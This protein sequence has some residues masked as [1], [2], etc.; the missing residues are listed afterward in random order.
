VGDA[1]GHRRSSEKVRVAT[2]GT[3]NGDDDDRR[4]NGADRAGEKE[5]DGDLVREMLAFAAGRI[6]ESEVEARTGAAKGARSPMREVQRNGYRDRDWDTRTGQIA[7]E[8][9][10]LRKGSY[11]PSFL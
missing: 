5:A 1:G 3:E 4:Q 9:P 11:F 7:L 2:P 8:I 6:M 10:K